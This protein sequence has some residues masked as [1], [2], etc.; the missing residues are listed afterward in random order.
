MADMNLTPARP[1]LTPQIWDKMF[2][3]EYIRSN[4]FMRYMGK[5]ENSIIQ[6]KD[7]L[8]VKNGDTITFAAIR[9]LV[10]AG[11]T[12]SI[13]EG[14]EEILDARSMKLTVGP[15]RHGVAVNNWDIQKSVIELRDAAK[16]ALMNWAKEKLRNDIITAL[17]SVGTVNGLTIPFATAT[18]TQKNLW[19]ASN[20][21]R[22]R[23]GAAAANF[24]AGVMA[25]ALLTLDTTNDRMTGALLSLAKRQAQ[26]ASP[27][28]RPTKVDDNKDEEWFVCFMPS[29]VFRDFRNDPPVQLLN[30]DA[31]PR[32]NGWAENPLFAGG[33][34]MWDGVICREIPEL[35][36]IP[37]AG[38]AGAD[39]AASFLC[40][41]QALGVGWAQRT[42]SA[43]QDRD[44]KWS[45]GAAI[46][47]IRAVGKLE[48]GRDATVDTSTLVDQGIFTIFTTAQADI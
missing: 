2:F 10:G 20:S 39:V 40:G 35:P 42:Q 21:D 14:N 47:E 9:R 11:V 44:Y 30:K 31:R 13:L 18:A 19:L 38:T 48:F 34:L 22:V 8:T 26:T 45:H 43:T 37:A 6:V 29:L 27:H 32:E 7:D 3:A 12:T 17:S 1:G 41:A 25:T 23:F 15:I 4:R 33:D 24:S 46:S 16:T 28:I 5:N 36:V